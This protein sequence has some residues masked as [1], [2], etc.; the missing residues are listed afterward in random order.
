[1]SCQKPLAIRICTKKTEIQDISIS[2]NSSIKVLNLSGLTCAIIRSNGQLDQKFILFFDKVFG[3]APISFTK[4]PN[5]NGLILGFSDGSLIVFDKCPSKSLLENYKR[6]PATLTSSPIKAAYLP[7]LTVHKI[8]NCHEFVNLKKQTI[9]TIPELK[10]FIFIEEKLKII[11][12]TNNGKVCISSIDEEISGNDVNNVRILSNINDYN[13]FNVSYNNMLQV[14]SN[15]LIVSFSNRIKVLNIETEEIISSFTLNVSISEVHLI[16]SNERFIEL[17]VTSKNEILKL[18]IDPIGNSLEIEKIEKIGI[19]GLFVNEIFYILVTIDGIFIYDTLTNR[20]INKC[21]Y[22]KYFLKYKN[23]MEEQSEGRW[24]EG[25]LSEAEGRRFIDTDLSIRS[26]T[27]VKISKLEGHKFLFIWGK[28]LAQIWDF[29]PKLLSKHQKQSNQNSDKGIIPGNK[30]TRKYSKYAV[31]SGIEDYKDE[32]M[33]EDHLKHL[34]QNLN[35][36]GL[37][38]E[39]LISYA[40]LISNIDQCNDNCHDDSTI[41]DSDTTSF[42]DDPELSMALKLSLTEM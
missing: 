40:K 37:T 13:S 31:N 32:K 9:L 24:S 8:G 33:E 35:I 28:S 5:P 18:K 22:P 25:R 34:R 21:S 17:F 16:S 1:M 27:H 6:I 38:E 10:E 2:N 23:E 39:E 12:I 26:Q 3:E 14:N 11:F 29:N 20:I 15:W 42:D 36:E 30:A 4:F 7:F 41:F 19:F